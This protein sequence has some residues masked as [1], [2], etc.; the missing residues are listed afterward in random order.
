MTARALVLLALLFAPFAAGCGS[1]LG[2]SSRDVNAKNPNPPPEGIGPNGGI[3]AEA[4]D[5][6]GGGRGSATP[7]GK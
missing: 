5:M 4:R 6:P 2:G 1:D 3:G 7:R